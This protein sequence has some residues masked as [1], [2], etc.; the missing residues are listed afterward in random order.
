MKFAC[1]RIY[2]SYKSSIIVVLKSGT[3]ET[4]D[5]TLS[6]LNALNTWNCYRNN[7]ANIRNSNRSSLKVDYR[8]LLMNSTTFFL[9][10]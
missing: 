2:V 4:S 9:N 7:T 3:S 10:F 6:T 5:K 1:S 8:G